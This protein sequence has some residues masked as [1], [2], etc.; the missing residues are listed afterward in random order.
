MSGV[1][2]RGAF[3]GILIPEIEVEY[4]YWYCPDEHPWKHI[5]ERELEERY[6]TEQADSECDCF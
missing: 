5:A 2:T 1:V 3:A 4:W 6:D